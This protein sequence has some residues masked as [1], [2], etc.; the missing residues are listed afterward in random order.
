[1]KKIALLLTLLILSA[2]QVYAGNGDLIVDGN[3]GIGTTNP[4]SKLDIH[5]IV[6]LSNF[7]S[8]S[9]ERSPVNSYTNLLL[10][11]ALVYNGNGTY[12]VIT[13]GGSN[14]FA[15]IKMDNAG[16][17]VG[18][19]KFYTGP[20][21][22]G[23][24]YTL[25]EGDLENYARMSI[26]GSNIGIGTLNPNYKLD[27]AGVSAFSDRLYKTSISPGNVDPILISAQSEWSAGEIPVVTLG[28]EQGAGGTDMDTAIWSYRRTPDET[29][30]KL[31]VGRGRIDV[32]GNAYFSGNVGIGTTA[33]A[34]T[35]HVNG[36][37]SVTNGSK[38]F[39][40]KDPRY[41]DEKRRLI[42]STIEGPEVGVYYRGEIKLENGKAVV[43]LPDYFEALTRKEN[44]TALLTAKFES[45]DEPLC[46]V[47]A[48]D[49][50][51]GSF[52]IRAYG[53]PD[54]TSCNHK[55]YWEVK[56]E[57]SDIAKLKVEQVRE[58]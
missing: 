22:S 8:F 12:T 26:V 3:V 27:V 49:V 18:A 37:F 11:G 7:G 54:I 46:A 52:S 13:D 55:V 6:K 34:A 47:A 16:G 48:S 58:K 36:S 23:N 51:D 29:V 32:L 56:A 19:I 5:G 57:R 33:P 39:D 31:V 14:Y 53:Q 44:R 15:G 50:K 41:N 25:S 43:K 2:S 40:I 30:N 45:D 4:S 17:N 9:S 24:N 1:M 28:Y 21:I 20:S 35:L 10:G 38:N 42:H